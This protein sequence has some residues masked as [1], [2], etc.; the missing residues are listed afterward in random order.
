[1]DDSEE[2]EETFHFG[3]L[4]EGIWVNSVE[5]L[6]WFSKATILFGL[7]NERFGEESGD[8]KE[9]LDTL[10]WSAD[11]AELTRILADAPRDDAVVLRALAD[12]NYPHMR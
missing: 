5:L 6:N 2:E 4:Y 9:I 12:G 3:I 10:D 1:M 11:Y 7:L 8:M